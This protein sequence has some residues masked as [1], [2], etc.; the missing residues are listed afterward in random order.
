MSNKSENDI[1]NVENFEVINNG[2]EEITAVI[3]KSKRVKSTKKFMFI[4]III[5]VL[6]VGFGIYYVVSGNLFKG[7]QD[8]PIYN[9]SDDNSVIFDDIND[10]DNVDNSKDINIKFEDIVLLT[11]NYFK[12]N[13]LSNNDD[14]DTWDITDIKYLGYYNDLPGVLY[15]VVKGNYKCLDNSSTCVYVDQESSEADG[16]N[17]FMTVVSINDF[18]IIDCVYS[19]TFESELRNNLE[20]ASKFTFV[21]EVIN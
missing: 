12:D 10:D 14:I 9:A 6:I 20:E 11:K 2:E 18:T 8:E 7:E 17:L 4:F 13:G 5:I 21:D 15:Y 16:L 3:E 1:N 19:R